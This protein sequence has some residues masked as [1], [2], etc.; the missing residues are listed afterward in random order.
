MQNWVV[1]RAEEF[2]QRQE[3]EPQRLRVLAEGD[4][5]F[6]YPAGFWK[7]RKLVSLLR[8]QKT[9]PLNLMSLA[10]PGDTLYKLAFGGSGELDLAIDLVRAGG[11]AFDV[12]LL[13]AGGND[14]FRR[15]EDAVPH[16]D[17]PHVDL[18]VLAQLLRDLDAW[19][20]TV[21]GRIRRRL[22]VAPVIVHGYGHPVPDGRGV[23]GG[24]GPLPG[25][26]LEPG[27]REKGYD[28]L[29]ERIAIAARL[30][31]AFNA[32]IAELVALPAFAHV[33]YV[34]LRPELSTAPSDYRKRWGNELHPTERGFD[35]VTARFAA[36]LATLP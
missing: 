1:T 3:R 9:L 34:D 19:Y 29:A 6:S 10:N 25:P 22:R 2:L 31:D 23:L 4:S 36:T 8:E 35:A 12:V 21:L 32:M 20:G 15:I 16:R 27:F 14:F 30:I 26:W 28:D 18:A 5:W 24:W 7:G 17:P 13:S 11:Q 33:R